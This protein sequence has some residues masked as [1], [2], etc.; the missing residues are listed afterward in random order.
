MPISAHAQRI[1]Q[2]PA[3]SFAS[4][5][6]AMATNA[7]PT[8]ALRDGIAAVV[9]DNIISMSD[10]KGRVTL[11]AFS[12]G[13]PRTPQTMQKLLPRVLRSLIDEQ[14]QL[15]EGKA[16]GLNVSQEEV[17]ATIKSL[18]KVNK[19]PNGDMEGLLRSNGIP[20]SAMRSQIKASLVW[21]KV[22]M[23][24][25]RPRIDIGADEIETVVERLRANQ[26]Q[27]D[28]LVSE[29]FL[30]VDKPQ[31]EVE[32][33]ELAE[34]LTKQIK[35]G[36]SFGAVARQ[37]SQGL[38]AATGGDL[39]WIQEGQ[40]ASELNN[41]LPT[42]AKNDVSQPLRGPAGYHILGLRDK[43][44]NSISDQSEASVK[45][46]Q[47]FRPFTPNTDKEALLKAAGALKETVL[48]CEGL[49]NK[50]ATSFPKWRLQDLG[51]VKMA[52]APEWL[53]QQI[54]NIPTGKASSPMATGKGALILFVCGRNAAESIDRDAIRAKLGTEKMGIM[55]RRAQRDLRRDAYID[56]RLK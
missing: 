7:Q 38:G 9:N 54:K 13:L 47:A 17:D 4:G 40:L 22:V 45:M 36:A 49:E 41:V 10:L 33:K 43:R 3:H 2:Q 51:E 55:A 6:P 23:R 56:V 14:L 37:F 21:K 1:N 31:D 24:T 39:G 18:A 20:F 46:K 32:I 11:A 42:L 30:A 12:S 28:Y 35:E 48:S 44:M 52:D 53:V 26:G 15:E 29:I 8:F 34:R 25:I 5:A 16:K 50:L 19:V 27:E